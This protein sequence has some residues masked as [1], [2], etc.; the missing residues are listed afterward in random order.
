VCREV[1]VGEDSDEIMQDAGIYSYSVDFLYPSATGFVFDTANIEASDMVLREVGL[2]FA[3]KIPF[4]KLHL[5]DVGSPVDSRPNRY[6]SDFWE[7]GPGARWKRAV[8]NVN[9]FYRYKYEIG[10]RD[11]GN[12]FALY[13]TENGRSVLADWGNDNRRNTKRRRR[14]RS[15]C[16]KY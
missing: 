2:V 13:L 8:E 7:I 4:I 3:G 11:D 12:N 6:S 16:S 5:M 9:G 15:I 1:I 10:L 14:V